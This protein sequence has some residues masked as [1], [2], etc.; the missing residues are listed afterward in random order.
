MLVPYKHLIH[1]TNVARIKCQLVGSYDSTCQAPQPCFDFTPVRFCSVFLCF[2]CFFAVFPHILCFL[3]LLLVSSV[4]PLFSDLFFFFRFLC[5]FLYILCLYLSTLSITY[6]SY[7]RTVLR[8]SFLRSF[9]ERLILCRISIPTTLHPTQ[10]FEKNLLIE[11]IY[12]ISF[13]QY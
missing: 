7:L 5:F 9:I 12:I 3:F 1:P 10:H 11:S 4:F 6:G 13:Q 8:S 2:F